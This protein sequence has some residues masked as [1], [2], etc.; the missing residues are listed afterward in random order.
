MTDLADTQ[1]SVS[2]QLPFSHLTDRLFVNAPFER[3]R[4]DLLKVFIDNRLQPEIDLEGN[5]LYENSDKDFLE[6]ARA[7]EDA[8][9]ACTLHAPF[10]DLAPGA[11]DPRILEATRNKLLRAFDLIDIFKPRSIVCHLGYED[12]KHSFRKDEWLAGSLETWREMLMVAEMNQTMICL[13]N[14]Y[15]TNPDQ[16]LAI[17][18]E[19][20][21]PSVRFCL[22]VGHVMSFAGNTWQEWLSPLTPWLGQLHLH[23]NLGGG[24]DHLAIGEG[25]F[26][27]QGLFDFLREQDHQPLITLEP[28]IEEGLWKSLQTLEKMKLPEPPSTINT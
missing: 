11:S 6:I 28:H 1:A 15:E 9:L 14:T 27:F 23:D 26:D 10:C 21:S 16:H 3:L 2:G 22:D 12:N 13:E 24:A 8:G 25:N 4:K 17:L 19:L 7:F 5:C 18:S 20:D